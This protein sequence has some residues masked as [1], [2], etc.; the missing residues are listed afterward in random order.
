[1]S[2]QI[3]GHG[4]HGSQEMHNIWIYTECNEWLL[5]LANA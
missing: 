5:Y 4:C 2:D 3:S 1:M